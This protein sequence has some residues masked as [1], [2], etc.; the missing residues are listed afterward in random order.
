MGTMEEHYYYTCRKHEATGQVHCLIGT[1]EGYKA[2]EYPFGYSSAKKV[3]VPKSQCYTGL[4][5]RYILAALF[6]TKAEDIR[7][8][9][10]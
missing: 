4:D 7:F 3:A 5:N 2:F 1:G 10:T 9:L 8:A 6:G